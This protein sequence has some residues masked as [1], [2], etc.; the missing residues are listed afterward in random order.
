MPNGFPWPDGDATAFPFLA[1]ID[2]YGHT[3]FSKAQMTRV[4][5]E[6]EALQPACRDDADR[7]HLGEVIRLAAQ[8]R[9]GDTHTF[10]SF[11]GD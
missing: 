10:L 6:L 5:P 9:D 2:E 8:C 1:T 3:Y 7:S 4:L 11:H